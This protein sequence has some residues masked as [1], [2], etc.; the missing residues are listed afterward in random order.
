MSRL[1]TDL[2]DDVRKMANRLVEDA[3]REQIWLI[4][5]QTYRTADQ[6]QAL[7]DRG[8]RTPGLIVTH[9]PPGY[10]WHEFRRAFDVAIKSFSGDKTPADVYD[11]PWGRIGDL[12]EAAGLDW[13]GR[14][15][16]PDQPHFEHSGGKTL[17]AMR[18]A[19]KFA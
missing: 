9:A 13:G 11:G 4:V 14:W 1:L 17:A 18:A 19:R 6:Q 3:S 7:Y 10:S 16:R 15:K 12:G 5:T 8:R 2:D